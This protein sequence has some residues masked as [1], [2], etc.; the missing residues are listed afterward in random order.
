MFFLETEW[1]DR[2]FICSRGNLVR[3]FLF[4]SSP[5]SMSNVHVNNIVSFRIVFEG[6]EFTFLFGLS[7]QTSKQ[8]TENIFG[9]QSFQGVTKDSIVA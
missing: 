4:S 5:E 8:L 9:C 3:M 1:D 2:I 7:K 6:F